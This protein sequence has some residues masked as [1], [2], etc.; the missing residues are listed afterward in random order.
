MKKFELDRLTREYERT[1]EKMK[2]TLGINTDTL[3]SKRQQLALD[4]DNASV[5]QLVQEMRE[6][7]DTIKHLQNQLSSNET[8]YKRRLAAY[9]NYITILE[10]EIRNCSPMDI[11]AN[12]RIRGQSLGNALPSLSSA[13]VLE[14][15]SQ[16]KQLHPKTH[17]RKKHKPNL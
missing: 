7:D 10:S 17:R 16:I 11:D 3:Y 4:K 5:L 6:R 1:K 15:P 12:F 2:L 8:Y 9:W 13:D 14:L